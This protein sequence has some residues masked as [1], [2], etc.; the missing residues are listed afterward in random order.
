MWL[1]CIVSFISA[2]MLA[3]GVYGNRLG[4]TD[5][6][7]YFYRCLQIVVNI[8]KIQNYESDNSGTKHVIT[9]LKNPSL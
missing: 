2:L 9:L 4:M 1:S 3:S 5:I 8:T 7:T 6:V